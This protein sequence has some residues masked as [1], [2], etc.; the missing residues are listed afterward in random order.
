MATDAARRKYRENNLEKDRQQRREAKAR[1]VA[2]NPEKHA[3][4]NRARAA[5]NRAAFPEKVRNAV[6]LWH[7]NNKVRVKDYQL[8]RAFGIS[9]E[10]W[11]AKF[12]A[13]GRVRDCC[14]SDTPAHVKGWQ[15]DHCHF[16]GELRGIICGPCNRTLTEHFQLN[17]QKL[18]RYIERYAGAVLK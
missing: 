6:K 12:E 9:L 3:L 13:Q 18:V 5:R 15:T 2:R 17:S 14:G 7:R 4:A 16:T 8:R 1:W 10:E 11:N